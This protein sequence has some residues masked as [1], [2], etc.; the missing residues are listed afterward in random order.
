M[1][2]AENLT[3]PNLTHFLEAGS[4]GK[5][6][7]SHR[8]HRKRHQVPTCWHGDR[9]HKERHLPRPCH[10]YLGAQHVAARSVV[11]REEHRLQTGQRDIMGRL[12]PTQRQRDPLQAALRRGRHVR[13]LGQC[14]CRLPGPGQSA[15][16][17]IC[18]HKK[19][20]TESHPEAANE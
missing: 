5:F 4:M 17:E 11:V 18:S 3:S 7:V 15:D 13:G 6:H 19:Y 2:V 20:I 16:Q 9:C 14:Q 10:K 8:K 1:K 12:S